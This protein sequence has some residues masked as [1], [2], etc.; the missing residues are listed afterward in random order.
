MAHRAAGGTAKNLRDSKSKR[1]GVKKFGG[2]KVRPGMIIIRQR[3]TKF[4]PGDGVKI[5]RDDT[6]YAVKSGFVKFTRRKVKKFT[7]KLAWRTFV[8]VVDK[9]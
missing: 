8:N 5:G 2:E 4:H 6:I 7:G 3:G 1:L 9:I